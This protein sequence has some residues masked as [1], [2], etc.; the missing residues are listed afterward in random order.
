MATTSSY[1]LKM[2]ATE[3]AINNAILSYDT[4]TSQQLTTLPLVTTD[5]GTRIVALEQPHAP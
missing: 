1:Q 2:Q 4:A 3:D 5:I